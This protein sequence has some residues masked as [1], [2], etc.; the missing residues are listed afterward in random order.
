MVS[1][2]HAK[3][4][5]Y[6]MGWEGFFFAIVPA[7]LR[8]CGGDTTATYYRLTTVHLHTYVKNTAA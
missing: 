4:A 3:G 5:E 1:V 7:L 8:S 6:E 2:F